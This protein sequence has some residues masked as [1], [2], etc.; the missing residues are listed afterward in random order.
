MGKA[1]VAGGEIE[2]QQSGSGHPLIFVSGLGGVGRYWEPQL[3]VFGK[4]YRVITYDQRGTGGSDKQQRSFTVDQMTAELG[5]LMD[6]LGIEK[7]HVVGLSTGGAIGQTLAIEYPQRLARMVVVSTWTHCDPWFRRLFEARR[8]MYR[9]AGSELHA[10]F[11]PLWLYPPDYVNAHDAEIEEERR[12][13]MAGAPP[14]EVSIG[15]I[16]AIMAFDRRADLHRIKT[17]TLIV[18]ADNDY[19]TPP[20]HAEALGRAISG[21]KV[22]IM[23]GGGHAIS[24]TRAEEFNRA[25]LDFLAV[26]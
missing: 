20:Y 19:I 24:K 26:D 1:R 17:P 8:T 23:K 6:A 10:Q 13:A 22:V 4:R 15:R 18:G 16:D 2:Y 7:A 5:G 12:K 14:V 3:P 9:E 11:H 21:S 25:V